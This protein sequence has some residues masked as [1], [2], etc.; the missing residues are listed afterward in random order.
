[1]AG[2]AVPF[3]RRIR[4]I[5]VAALGLLGMSLLTRR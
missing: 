1:V 5:V 4:G 2:F 3:V